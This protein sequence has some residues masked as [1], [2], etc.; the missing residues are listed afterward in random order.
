MPTLSSIFEAITCCHDHHADINQQL[1]TIIDNQKLMADLSKLTAATERETSVVTSAITLITG[2]AAEI[3]AAKN[4]PAEIDAIANKMN[5]SA[6]ALAA[7]VAANTPAE[8][9]PPETAPQ[10]GTSAEP[11]TGGNL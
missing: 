11:G 3:A 8:P 1:A 7:A 2:L 5:A 10:P 9:A 4:D 6:D